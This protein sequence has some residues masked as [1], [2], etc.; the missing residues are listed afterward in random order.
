MEFGHRKTLIVFGVFFGAWLGILYAFVTQA[1]NWV[2]MPGIPLAP[3][4]STLQNYLLNYLMMGAMLGLITSLPANRYIGM[5]LGGVAF[6]ATLFFLVLYN[7]WGLDS[8]GSSVLLMLIAFLPLSTLLMSLSLFVRLGVDAQ[9]VDP[10]RPHLWARKI[11]IPA[12]LSL[13]AVIVGTFSLYGERERIAF[14]VV[15]EI[16]QAGLQ[17]ESAGALPEP[18]KDVNGFTENAQG[19]FM[20][21]W[22]DRTDTFFGPRPAG[23][24]MSQFLIIAEFENNFRFACIFSP[25][26][27]Q[28]NCVVH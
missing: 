1:I 13:V 26:R 7:Q 15:N 14:R 22:S 19:S 9:V 5:V 25:N 17:A 12:A 10:D 21:S 2:F 3:P 23:S 20:L 11:L 8:F 6:G 27:M 18:L 24:E 28:P 4:H 16:T